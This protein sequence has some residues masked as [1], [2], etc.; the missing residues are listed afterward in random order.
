MY[1]YAF[2]YIYIY[3]YIFVYIRG[4]AGARRA[5]GEFPNFQI[6]QNAAGP[7]AVRRGVPHFD[8]FEH[9]FGGAAVIFIVLLDCEA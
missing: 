4:R 6:D 9:F 7:H 8:R 5:G 2:I 1:L 3:S